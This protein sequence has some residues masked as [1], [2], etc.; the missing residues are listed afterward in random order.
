MDLTKMLFMLFFPP[1]YLHPSVYTHV[2][3]NLVVIPY[4]D[5]NINNK[6]REK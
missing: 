6:P 2:L 1:F 5:I 3:L 4:I